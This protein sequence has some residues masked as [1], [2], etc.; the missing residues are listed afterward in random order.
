MKTKEE[1]IIKNWTEAE[2]AKVLH[3]RYCSPEWAFLTQVRNQTGFS[4]DVRTA[5][6]IAMNLYPSR[7]MEINGFE[8]KVSRNDWLNEL[9]NPEKSAEL[10]QFCHKWWVVVPDRNFIKEGELPITW[11]LI[12]VG[13]N[14]KIVKPAPV[15]EAKMFSRE[16]IASLFRN[17][18]ESFVHPEDVKLKMDLA[19]DQA[20][21]AMHEDF[22]EYE[23]LKEQV[24]NFQ[25]ESGITI[26][27]RWGDK[28][29]EVGKAVKLI[30]EQRQS[31]KWSA[32]STAKG[33]KDLS[34]HFSKLIKVLDIELK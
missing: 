5:D 28:G 24:Q 21:W 29:K 15:L 25:K 7:G 16:F 32:E 31:L 20:K 11:G 22:K 8:I 1:K 13:K 10:Q 27:E 6:A 3:I 12:E 9:K 33:L 19:R 17:V 30:M 23:R 2:V 14:C 26:W 18:C 4:R 34:E